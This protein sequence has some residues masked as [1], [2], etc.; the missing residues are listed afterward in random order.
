MLVCTSCG[1][2]YQRGKYCSLCGSVLKERIL[3]YETTNTLLRSNVRLDSVRPV[4]QDDASNVYG[5]LPRVKKEQ[6]SYMNKTANT[7]MYN[8]ELSESFRH[9]FDEAL[10][11]KEAD[12]QE[13]AG[14]EQEE[15]GLA[16]IV[17]GEK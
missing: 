17:A 7:E 4:S 2:T 3:N 14:P 12:A 9:S 15:E 6:A 5:T 11:K 8:P 16:D 13:D 1:K 10:K